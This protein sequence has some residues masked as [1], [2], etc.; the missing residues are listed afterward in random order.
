MRGGDL[1]EDLI[2]VITEK[3][4]PNEPFNL[5]SEWL[6]SSQHLGV[7]QKKKGELIMGGDN[8][9]TACLY[10]GVK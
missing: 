4:L 7:S 6:H 10:A 2:T 9:V 1:G 8:L 5:V 3:N